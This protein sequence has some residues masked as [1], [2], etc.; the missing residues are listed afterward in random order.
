MSVMPGFGVNYAAAEA[1]WSK[2]ASYFQSIGLSLVR[3][4]MP[5]VSYPWA[6]GSTGPGGYAFWRNCA[7]YFHNAGFWVTWG[8]S[9]LSGWANGG[10]QANSTNW[11]N[12]H[13]SVV[14]EATYLQSNNI[15]IDDFSIGNELESCI[16]NSTLT[17]QQVRANI[18]QLAADVKAVY[19]LGTVSYSGDNQGSTHYN[20][21]RSDLGD[22][23]NWLT[24]GLG[25]LDYMAMHPYATVNVGT[26]TVDFSNSESILASMTGAYGSKI[27]VS[28]FN[29]DFNTTNLFTLN[30]SVAIVQ[31]VTMLEYIIADKVGKF[32]VFQWVGNLNENSQFSQLFTNGTMNPMWFDFFTSQPLYYTPRAATATRA[33]GAARDVGLIRVASNYKRYLVR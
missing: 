3:P 14:A 25:G 28:E 6:I 18:R 33:L 5:K 11:S 32:L 2:D 9:V 12:F 29:L 16:D 20:N 10:G 31:M 1:N 26:Q 13:D 8:P 4:V 17:Y 19:T 30:P 15:V 23:S 21:I 27:Y 22:T 24:E 7:E